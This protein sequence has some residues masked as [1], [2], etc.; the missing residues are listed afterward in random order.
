[1]NDDDI[2]FQVNEDASTATNG[3]TVPLGRTLLADD[4][5]SSTIPPG[6]FGWCPEGKFTACCWP[7]LFVP[8]SPFPQFLCVF[9]TKGLTCEHWLCCAPIQLEHIPDMDTC[10]DPRHGA[11]RPANLPK[12]PEDLP[13]SPGE[14]LPACPAPWTS[15]GLD[16]KWMNGTENRWSEIRCFTKNK[17]GSSISIRRIVEL[18]QEVHRGLLALHLGCVSKMQLLLI[19]NPL[20]NIM[21]AVT[22]FFFFNLIHYLFTIGLFHLRD[23][24]NRLPE[25]LV[26]LK[27]TTRFCKNQIFSARPLGPNQKKPPLRNFI[28]FFVT[29]PEFPFL[30]TIANA[31]IWTTS[32]FSTSSDGISSEMAS[33]WKDTF[34]GRFCAAGYCKLE[35]S[36]PWRIQVGGILRAKSNSQYLVKPCFSHCHNIF[37]RI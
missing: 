24:W 11:R 32:N 15:A 9:Y 37:M 17:K 19:I 1:M 31:L 26:S 27:I 3:I 29:K 14:R 10:E 30:I 20:L 12:R 36:K 13:D 25:K 18:F 5:D 35:R 16:W 21:L 22:T 8:N 6:K 34:W 23:F 4:N 7:E 2:I 33:T 28:R